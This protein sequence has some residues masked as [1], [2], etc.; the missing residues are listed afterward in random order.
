[1][2]VT[3]TKLRTVEREG[4]LSA[5]QLE[6][7]HERTLGA[8]NQLAETEYKPAPMRVSL[9]EIQERRFYVMVQ[10]LRKNGAGFTEIQS[11]LARVF[12]PAVFVRCGWAFPVVSENDK[13]RVSAGARFNPQAAADN[14][15]YGNFQHTRRR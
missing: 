15:N 9:E 4:L 3:T 10:K 6:E 1:M 8:L 13:A 11:Q 12:P 2:E 5:E 14:A 7:A